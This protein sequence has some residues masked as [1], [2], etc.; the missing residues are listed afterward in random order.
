MFALK[1]LK[2]PESDANSRNASSEAYIASR[3]LVAKPFTVITA[4]GIGK[5]VMR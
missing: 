1:P 4:P 5:T 3:S 2:R